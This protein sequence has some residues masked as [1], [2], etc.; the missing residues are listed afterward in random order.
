MANTLDPVYRRDLEEPPTWT[1]TFWSDQAPAPEAPLYRDAFDYS[2]GWPLE[3]MRQSQKSSPSF[4]SVST[5][6]PND[7]ILKTTWATSD[8]WPWT[9]DYQWLR[10]GV[11]L[12]DLMIALVIVLA[13]TR[14]FDLWLTHR[15][16]GWSFR[17]KEL[18][19]VTAVSCVVLGWWQYHVNLQKKEN[20]VIGELAK[21]SMWRSNQEAYCG[22]VWL[23]K[24]IGNPDYLPFCVHWVETEIGLDNISNE[25]LESLKNLTYLK[26]VSLQNRGLQ[27]SPRER[28]LPKIF[29][30]PQMVSFLKSFRHLRQINFYHDGTLPEQIP[31]FF[32]LKNV[33]RFNVERVGIEEKEYQRLR[34]LDPRVLA[35]SSEECGFGRRTSS[36]AGPFQL[37]LSRR[38]VTADDFEKFLPVLDRISELKLG[39]QADVEAL[40][41]FLLEC[42][43]SFSVSFGEIELTRQQL[44][45]LF[46]EPNKRNER[47]TQFE[48]QFQQAD[49]TVADFKEWL[50]LLVAGDLSIV[51]VLN[52]NWSPET[53]SDLQSDF[54]AR[55]ID[56]EAYR[57]M[58][59]DGF[60]E[61]DNNDISTPFL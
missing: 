25:E 55:G 53:I 60:I 2:H 12:L 58:N 6:P 28:G 51:R 43:E 52:S 50:P 5:W 56:L 7:M 27:F 20:E 46:T 47:K 4:P 3:W 30:A 45:L 13:V 32:A 38:D 24:L 9:G 19:L 35:V 59:H 41:A 11:L 48:I 57:G 22:P 10:I 49:L 21:R 61:P 34:Q 44:H 29:D 15:R 40:M 26:R 33:D 39:S 54:D 36:A 37:D 14:L 42:P 17:L 31:Q 16:R 18:L 8:A 1:V 23:G